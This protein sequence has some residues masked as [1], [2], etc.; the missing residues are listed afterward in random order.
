MRRLSVNARFQVHS[1][2]GAIASKVAQSPVERFDPSAG[3]LAFKQARLAAPWTR[4]PNEGTVVGPAGFGDHGSSVER[5]RGGRRDSKNFAKTSCNHSSVS[6][7]SPIESTEHTDREARIADTH[8]GH[9][10]GQVT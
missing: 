8:T 9:G 7:P 6:V 5:T 2:V 1:P 10:P 4:A 3:M